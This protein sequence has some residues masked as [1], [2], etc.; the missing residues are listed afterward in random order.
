MSNYKYCGNAFAMQTLLKWTAD[1]DIFHSVWARIASGMCNLFINQSN[2][3]TN[4]DS[5]SQSVLC[6]SC[7]E[8][9]ADIFLVFPV[10]CYSTH[11]L[12]VFNVYLY[13]VSKTIY[14]QYTKHQ[15]SIFC[16]WCQLL[17]QGGDKD[18]ILKAFVLVLVGFF[19]SVHCFF[20]IRS[21]HTVTCD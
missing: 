16:L 21:F 6:W 19:H 9:Q 10:F 3:R 12:H 1:I 7:K 8:L 13:A 15:F 11:H 5:W 20:Q 17:T 4:L 2:W 18:F 14:M